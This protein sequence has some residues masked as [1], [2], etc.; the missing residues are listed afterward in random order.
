MGKQRHRSIGTTH[1]DGKQGREKEEEAER[2][3]EEKG[4]QWRTREEEE[5]KTLA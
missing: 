5:P 2:R 4:G 3:S 1:V